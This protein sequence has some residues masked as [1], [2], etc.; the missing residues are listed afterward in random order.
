MTTKVRGLS[1]EEKAA[2]HPLIVELHAHV[3]KCAACESRPVPLTAADVG[4]GNF[5]D[6]GADLYRR[7]LK[8][9]AG[10]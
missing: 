8:W 10:S 7:W 1:E 3:L 2:L 9:L 4:E 6:V 5:C